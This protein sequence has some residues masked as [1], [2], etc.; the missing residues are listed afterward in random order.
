MTQT[1]S[2]APETFLPT[3]PKMNW[4]WTVAMG[5]VMLFGGFV[6]LANPFAASLTVEAVA[7]AAFLVAGVMQIVLAV[8]REDG[9]TNARLVA[10]ALGVLLILFAISLLL[11]PLAGLVSLTILMA[12]FFAGVG[13]VRILLSMR[14]RTRGGWGWLL[15]SGVVSLALSL[16]ILLAL[17]EAALGLLGIFLGIELI[18]AGAASIVLGLRARAG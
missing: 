14:M 12:A 16:L 3:P 11:Q 2:S 5:L 17:P 4:G 18:A 9:S 7:A 15:A 8:R 1:D 10:G 13:V 6:A